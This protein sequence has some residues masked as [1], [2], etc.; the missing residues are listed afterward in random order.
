MVIFLAY[1]LTT[2]NWYIFQIDF[3]KIRLYVFGF[4]HFLRLHVTTKK[5]KRKRKN[6]KR[7][8]GEGHCGE[9]ECGRGN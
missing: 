5:K 3:H 9:R 8:T 1:A 4:K 7:G 2:L 6:T